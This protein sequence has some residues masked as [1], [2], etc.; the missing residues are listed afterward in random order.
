MSNPGI[1]LRERREELHL[2]RSGVESLTSA[3]TSKAA[4]E[5]YRIRRGRH[6]SPGVATN[7]PSGNVA[8]MRVSPLFLCGMELQGS[9]RRTLP[10]HTADG[11]IVQVRAQR[12]QLVGTVSAPAGTTV[13]LVLKRP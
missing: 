13:E 3:S 1:W 11:Q 7:R 4:N 9:D 5:R 6:G 12:D 2:T 8:I 10:A